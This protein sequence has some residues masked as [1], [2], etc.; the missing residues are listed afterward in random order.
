MVVSQGITALQD[1]LVLANGKENSTKE[2]IRSTLHRITALPLN[3]LWWFMLPCLF[4]RG[5]LCRRVSQDSYLFKS[6]QFI[7]WFIYIWR[8]INLQLN[9]WQIHINLFL[10]LSL[11][12]KT[13]FINFTITL[14]LEKAVHPMWCSQQTA[15]NRNVLFWCQ[16]LLANAL[17]VNAPSLTL[18]F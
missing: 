11:K 15:Q 7:H 17:R 5:K 18:G 2:G 3:K 4:F 6:N 8:E 12:Q 1:I 9:I 13:E 10:H 14:S 16:L